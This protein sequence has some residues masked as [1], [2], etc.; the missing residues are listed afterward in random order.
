MSCALCAG[1]RTSTSTAYNT[2]TNRATAKKD[3]YLRTLGETGAALVGE[4]GEVL[5]LRK[6]DGGRRV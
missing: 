5:I 4:Y 6:K 1:N 3:D 2:F